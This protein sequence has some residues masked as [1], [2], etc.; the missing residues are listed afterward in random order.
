V[1]NV[2]GANNTSIGFGSLFYNT[3]NSN[4]AIGMYALR[5]KTTGDNNIAIGISSGCCITTGACNVILGSATGNGFGA[6][7]KNIFIS[8]GA[9]NIRMFVT[10]STGFV[11][12][13]PGFTAPLY[14]LHVSSSFGG[15]SIYSTNDIAAFSDESVKTELQVIDNALEK[16]EQIHG[17][18]YVRTDDD[19]KTRR[20]GV[21]AQEI[22]KVL[23]EVVT[24]N[25]DGTLNV[26]YPNLVA[27]L[28]EAIK[29]LNQEI[30]EL[31]SK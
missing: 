8:D 22:Q 16:I 17:Y 12:V 31:K 26:A 11:G 10:G 14:P 15:I 20:A 28:I 18:T 6:Q 24:Q 2:T 21:I 3:C 9:G 23:P 1:A 30:K 5:N 25:Q 4:T 7:S 29:E 13:G 19:S 27:L